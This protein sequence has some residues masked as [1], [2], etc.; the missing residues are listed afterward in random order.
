MPTVG[1]RV[2]GTPG[3]SLFGAEA[4]DT[5]GRLNLGQPPQV[6]ALSVN[7]QVPHTANVAQ[8][9]GRSPHF[10]GEHEA[11]VILGQTSK[12]HV[13]VEVKHLAAFVSGEGDALAVDGNKACRAGISAEMTRT[14]FFSQKTKTGVCVGC[15][16]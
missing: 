9:E 13:P 5:R 10:R 7:E 12:I 14:I 6:T 11:L 1:T 8:A 3:V 15:A 4:A 16:K 2:P